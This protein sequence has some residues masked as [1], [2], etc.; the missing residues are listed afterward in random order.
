VRSFGSLCRVPFFV[1][2]G[3]VAASCHATGGLHS[4]SSLPFADGQYGRSEIQP[5]SHPFDKI[6]HIVI[7]IQE[8]RSFN[9]LF[10]GYPG[11]KTAKY[12]Y[13]S[14]GKKVELQ[15]LTLATKWDL[16]HN[17]ES[18]F[19]SCNG[20]GNIPGTDCKMNG[21]DKETWNCGQPGYGKCPNKYPPYS[22]VPQHQVQPYFDMAHQYVLADEFFAS[23]FDISSFISHEYIIAGVNPQSSA[24]YPETAW[25][26]PGGPIDK[27][28]SLG[29]DRKIIRFDLVPCWKSPTLASELDAKHI[30]W[31]Y[32]AAAVQGPG[33]VKNCR[34]NG[35]DLGPDLKSG[36][37]GIWSAYQSISDICYGPD[38][39][40]DVIS[41]PA[42]FLTDVQNGK[43][44]A[45]TWITP[46]FL[47]SDHGGNG[48]TTGP[49]WVTSVVNAIGESKF[50][51]STA[52]FIFWDDP[53]GWYDPVAP[54]YV[55][56]DGLGFRLPLLIISPYAKKGLVSHVHYE[57]GSIL[58]FIEDRFGLQ[59]LAASDARANSPEADCFNFTQ[60]PRK[61]VPIK[62]ALDQAYFKRQP[63]DLRPP[64]SE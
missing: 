10:N 40:R 45:V 59:R 25:G 48:S 42:Q 21:F 26:C 14:T 4:S 57:H 16:Q 56:N 15:P 11:A 51:D 19:V 52:I 12:G 34:R 27:T 62:A 60:P 31:A 63:L 41:P 33:A 22:Y 36:N 29:K 53:G 2:L 3:T 43:L 18:F 17:S 38:W 9:N 64:D 1:A 24:N 55:D 28:D 6:Q 44:R 20:S 7:V 30:S 8:N 46:T 47:N 54:A 35:P 23:N 61:F 58:K 39:E 37:Q 13:I 50:W 5:Y 32:Y 49:S